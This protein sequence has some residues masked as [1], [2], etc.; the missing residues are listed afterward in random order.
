MIAIDKIAEDARM[1]GAMNQNL[2]SP[3]TSVCTMHASTKLC[4]GCF[5]TIE[6][7]TAWSRMGDEDK[8]IVWARIAQRIEEVTP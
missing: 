5:R 3:C 6:E 2:P 8:R 1:A 4:N 7:I